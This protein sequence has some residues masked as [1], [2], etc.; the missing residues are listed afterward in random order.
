MLPPGTVFG[1][2][3]VVRANAADSTKD[4]IVASFEYS[5]I[6]Y[7]IDNIN[8]MMMLLWKDDED[9]L[10]VG[11]FGTS[12]SY[13]TSNVVAINAAYPSSKDSNVAAPTVTIT[14]TAG[15]AFAFPAATS[16]GD[17]ASST[18]P[19]NNGGLFYSTVPI[20]LGT[21]SSIAGFTFFCGMEGKETIKLTV[22]AG[23]TVAAG[24]TAFVYCTNDQKMVLFQPALATL[25]PSVA[26]QITGSVETSNTLVP[27]ASSGTPV[28]T[29]YMQLTQYGDSACKTTSLTKYVQLGTCQ[30]TG[31]D[32]SVIKSG[33]VSGSITTFYGTPYLS[34][35]CDPSTVAPQG[36]EP[37]GVDTQTVSCQA[38]AEGASYLSAFY[39][40]SMPATP[41]AGQLA[42]YTYGSFAT[43]AAGMSVENTPYCALKSYD[44]NKSCSISLVV[45]YLMYSM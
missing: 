32:Y 10:F 43:C 28:T 36:I 40:S 6:V 13:S 14:D 15:N 41:P 19:K 27:A 23:T 3:R 34:N 18:T 9:N 37:D 21:P 35:N 8:S 2:F 22:P 24:T 29:G 16:N 33:S 12:G 39:T 38:Q 7:T 25:V 42:L 1:G 17:Y 31:L 30:Q 20:P 11:R 26:G 44:F 4:T 45:S 5:N